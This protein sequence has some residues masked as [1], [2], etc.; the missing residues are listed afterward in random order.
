M[1]SP[2]N[3]QPTVSGEPLTEDT[4]AAAPEGAQPEAHAEV[5]ANLPAT[6]RWE[7]PLGQG[8]TS[9]QLGWQILP[10]DAIRGAQQ[11][12]RRDR[13]AWV[14]RGDASVWS[15]TSVHCLAW[16]NPMLVRPVGAQ[17]YEL[18]A[19]ARTW[20]LLVQHLGDD[21]C[22]PALLLHRP[23]RIPAALKASL[24][25]LDMVGQRILHH[26]GASLP[27][28]WDLYQHVS[29]PAQEGEAPA[30]LL[31]DDTKQTLARALGC[32]KAALSVRTQPSAPA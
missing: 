23:R 3:G 19:G 6:L 14:P 10:L 32:T 4:P 20:A 5:H 25:A 7:V 29:S 30:R 9:A 15:P 27:E 22:A 16:L 24:R 12:M 11:A 21:A 17:R 31:S 26:W 18:L 13:A 2:C 8:K 28:L 1:D